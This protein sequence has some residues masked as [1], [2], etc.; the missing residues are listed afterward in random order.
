MPVL[1][2]SV[3]IPLV[4]PVGVAH[5]WR[6]EVLVLVP[7]VYRCCYCSGSALCLFFSG[8]RRQDRIIQY[9]AVA[10]DPGRLGSCRRRQCL[11]ALR[12]AAR[13]CDCSAPGVGDSRS[14][15][16]VTLASAFSS[17][18][19]FSLTQTIEVNRPY[20]RGVPE[21]CRSFCAVDNAPIVDR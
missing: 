2:H 11:V 7:L 10:G 14:P 15:V 4:P 9:S 21:L 17:S 13:C 12:R 1:A 20:L 19:E 18:P 16:H 5:L 8:C 6:R 3:L